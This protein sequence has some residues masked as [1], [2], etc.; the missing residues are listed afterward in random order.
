MANE[1]KKKKQ[2]LWPLLHS[3][4]FL[5]QLSP[6]YYDVMGECAQRMKG[7]YLVL[8]DCNIFRH[9]VIHTCCTL[10]P[11]YKRVPRVHFPINPYFTIGILESLISICLLYQCFDCI[12]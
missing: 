9:T 1:E 6:Q 10:E 5:I 7:G 4:R 2:M 3:K 11:L 8:R 12:K